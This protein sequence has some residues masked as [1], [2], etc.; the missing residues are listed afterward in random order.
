MKTEYS[1]KITHCNF[2]AGYLGIFERVFYCN[3]IFEGLGS[4]KQRIDTLKEAK[5]TAA[6]KNNCK[7]LFLYQLKLAKGILLLQL[8][9]TKK[10][11]L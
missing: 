2:S 6:G 4:F 7:N 3:D 11:E 10:Y 9:D 8:G 5:T 1:F